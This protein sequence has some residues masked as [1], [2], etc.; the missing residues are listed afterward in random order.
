MEEEIDKIILN[1]KERIILLDW[2]LITKT[3][4][5][6]ESDIKI[7]VKSATYLRM[8]RAI[9]R[10]KITKAKFI[11]RDKASV[12]YEEKLFDYVL[13]NNSPIDTKRKVKT[14]YDK[15]IVPRKF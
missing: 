1:N 7:L 8:N 10:D 6:N 14:L 15:S 9:S 5:F 2:I 13:E 12:K 3:K 4:Y 11:E